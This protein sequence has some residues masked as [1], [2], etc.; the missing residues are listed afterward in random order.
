MHRRN[1][2]MRNPIRRKRAGYDA[3]LTARASSRRSREAQSLIRRHADMV[4]RDNVKGILVGSSSTGNAATGARGSRGPARGSAELAG[5]PGFL[6]GPSP[7]RL[8][9][10]AG[11]RR[12]RGVRPERL[13][14][15]F[16]A[17]LAFQGDRLW[18]HELDRI[19]VDGEFVGRCPHCD[20]DM[21]SWERT[22]FLRHRGMA[23]TRHSSGAQFLLALTQLPQVDR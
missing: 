8:G 21:C 17:A 12:F 16:Q 22:L 11:A 1:G 15:L 13:R 7:G 20:A 19:N 23:S 14:Y 3:A 5:L 10:R 9:W 18:G 6:A 2:P 4:G